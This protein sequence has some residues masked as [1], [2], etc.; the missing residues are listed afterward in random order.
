MNEQEAKLATQLRAAA[1]AAMEHGT[2]QGAREAIEA[3]MPFDRETA[4]EMLASYS[5]ETGDEEGA[6]KALEELKEIAPDKP[7]TKFISARL[8]YMKGAKASLIEPMEALLEEDMNDQVKE[9]IYNILGRVCRLLGQC[10]KAAE[11]DLESS[12]V[13]PKLAASQYGNYLFDLHYL[14]GRTPEE[15]RAA[16]AKYDTFYADVKR[17]CHRRRHSGKKLRVGYISADFRYHVVLRFVAAML[18]GKGAS[19]F[20]VYAYMTGREDA[21]SKEL[22]KRVDC[23]RNLRGLTAEQAARR[24]YEDEIDI[25]VE[26]GGHTTGN[27]LNILAYKPAPVQICGIGYWA[28][29][30]L[31]AVDYFLGDV[32]LDDEETQ[33][34]F[35]EKLLVLPHTH[36]CY[37]E[38]GDVPLPA[39]EPPCMRNGYI[40]FGSFNNFS[41]ASDETL[42]L[43][44][45]ILARTPDSRLLLKGELFDNPENREYLMNRMERMGIPQDRVEARGFTLEY[46]DEYADMDI[47]LDTFPYPGG[48]TTCDAIFMGVPVVTL[49]GTDHGSRFGKSLLMNLG[50]GEL[51]ANTPEEYV[52]KAVGLAGDKELLCA[53]RKNLRDMMRRS[54]LMDEVQY[55]AD[56]AAAYETIWKDYLEA[57]PVPQEGELSEIADRM[58]AF[59]R[60]GDKRQALAEADRIWAAESKMPDILARLAA[61]AVE[62][63]DAALARNAAEKLRAERPQDGYALYLSAAAA[64]LDKDAAEAERL[65]EAALAAGTLTDAQTGETLFLKACIQKENGMYATAAETYLAASKQREPKPRQAEAYSRYLLSLYLSGAKPDTLRREAAGYGAFFNDI[66][67]YTHNPAEEHHDALHIG[68]ILHGAAETNTARFLQALFRCF[69]R[70]R[71]E[72]Y[73][74]VLEEPDAYCAGF[75]AS[76]T[77]KRTLTGLSAEAAARRIREDGIDI[78]VDLTGHT[79]KNGLP[80]LAYRPAPIQISGVGYPATTGLPTI[81]YFLADIH[82]APKGTERFFTEELIRLSESH[83]CFEAP[84]DAPKFPTG[85]P[86]DEAGYLTF[87]VLTRWE[88]V[89]DEALRAWAEILRRMPEARLLVQDGVFADEARRADAA[90][91]MEA[92][93]IDTAR[94]DFEAWSEEKYLSAYERVDIALDTYPRTGRRATCE[95][96]YMGIP[97][98]TMN[99][100]GL[101][102][103]LGAGFLAN[104]GLAELCA[105]DWASYAK[106]ATRLA[107]DR[108]RLTDLHL[109]LRRTI[110]QTALMDGYRYL[111]A[112]EEAYGNIFAKWERS[113][114]QKVQMPIL[115]RRWDRMQAEMAEERWEAAAATGGRLV[116]AG[117]NLPQSTIQMSD[118]YFN[119]KDDIHRLYWT[120]R[121]IDENPFGRVRLS[122]WLADA[123]D[124]RGYSLD[125]LKTL[126]QMSASWTRKVKS[127]KLVYNAYLHQGLIT[128]I[129]GDAQESRRCYE[130]AYRMGENLA[131]R[132]GAYGSMLFAY[133]NLE[134]PQEELFE[135]SME[136]TNIVREIVPY[137]HDRHA[138]THKKI[139]VGYISPD[140]RFHVMYH[141][142]YAFFAAYD[143]ERFEVYAYSMVTKEDVYTEVLKRQ[144]NKWRDIA[145]KSAEEAAKIIYEDEIDILFELAGHTTGNCLL[146]LAYKPAPIQISGLG[147]MATTGLSAVDYFLTDAFVDPPGMHEK[148]FVEKLLYVSSHFCYTAVGFEGFAESD[149]APCKKRGWVLFGVFNQYKKVTD[150]MIVAWREI[151]SR[152]PK[153]KIL[154]KGPAFSS[155][156]VQDYAYRRM[157]ALGLPMDRIIFEAGTLDY[158]NRYLDVDISLDTYPWPGGGTTCD[159]LYMGVPMVSRYGDARGTRFSYG[160]LAAVGLEDL[161]TPTVKDYIEKAVALALDQELLDALHKNLRKMMAK[162]PLTD[163]KKYMRDLEARYEEIWNAWKQGQA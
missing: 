129:L 116:A 125:S 10:E 141:F 150:E 135:K 118:V 7:Y 36:F 97:V 12:K 57:Q 153:S 52:Q 53:F 73:A 122:V 94:V 2:L 51:V 26:L 91:R 108:E 70:A 71:F 43:W 100:K 56:L 35:T 33:K 149:G 144:V 106:K 55:G 146:A 89:T 127:P 137:Q 28:S 160:I 132:S 147:Y 161:A 121:A 18:R 112:L 61:A 76:A 109:T 34:A 131:E 69:D 156:Q 16:A 29:T 151:L 14:S 157:K 84:Q 83:L 49:A 77:G 46:L 138:R 133:N 102:S 31:S 139:R 13:S 163:V 22:E 98:V 130:A 38:V 72:V 85:A 113:A 80:V 59:L 159:S 107:K 4:L 1:Y 154:F 66:R 19:P 17:F 30:G 114:G 32:Y 47:A 8:E 41:K 63:E 162:S 134:L 48:G 54:P 60:D 40:T 67:T 126:R 119:L 9:R 93:G 110:M 115:Q 123:Q 68:Y 24:I 90:A 155:M 88:K 37:K 64:W 124:A 111:E 117:V 58:E 128:H 136:Y 21:F 6:E 20:S 152:V 95:A 3:F 86:A 103:H 62:A 27:A 104:A 78:L 23:W 87:G 158:M 25:L 45:R 81:D 148:Y 74:Y 120:K 92:A 5:I 145:K 142:V 15:F 105:A 96:L 140:F 101:S 143:H 39:S 50:L 75:L 65:A 11:Y 82:T 79:E 44:A 42:R 99:G